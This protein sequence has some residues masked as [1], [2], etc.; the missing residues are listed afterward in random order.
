MDRYKDL[1]DVY[2]DTDTT[3]ATTHYNGYPSEFRDGTCGQCSRVDGISPDIY[4]INRFTQA[5]CEG[6][7]SVDLDPTHTDLDA[8]HKGNPPPLTPWGIKAIDSSLETTGWEQT[9][10]LQ[11]SVT[12]NAGFFETTF[13]LKQL[14][15]VCDTFMS[16][17][18]DLSS[19]ISY[20]YHLNGPGT[21]FDLSLFFNMNPIN[22]CSIKSCTY[23]EETCTTPATTFPEVKLNDQA[24]ALTYPFPVHKY[25][26][27]ICT[28]NSVVIAT[29]THPTVEACSAE[30]KAANGG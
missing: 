29:Y 27:K 8:T 4:C 22:G 14:P 21:M 3:A 19:P 20:P 24:T 23:Y 28:L 6:L 10:C 13:T 9:V 17:N 26:G 12:N 5:D 15:L 30:C 2:S 11:C 7:F 18:P 1:R 16:P 25:Q